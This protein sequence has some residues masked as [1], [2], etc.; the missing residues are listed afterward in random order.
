[1]NLPV[2]FNDKVAL[3]KGAFRIVFQT[4]LLE[5]T[6][7]VCGRETLTDIPSVVGRVVW[8][9]DLRHLPYDNTHNDETQVVWG[10]YLCM[11][12]TQQALGFKVNIEEMPMS[13][14]FADNKCEL[15]TK[16]R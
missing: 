6:C 3:P 11:D 7:C 13:D 8:T 2:K 12:C 5:H 9:D 15:T 10:L 1:M 4:I 16:L 14:A